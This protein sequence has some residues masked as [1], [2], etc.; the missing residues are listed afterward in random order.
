MYKSVWCRVLICLSVIV[1]LTLS[2]LPVLSHADTWDEVNP[3]YGLE[4]GQYYSNLTQE[5]FTEHAI[6]AVEKAYKLGLFGGCRPVYIF[7]DFFND[8]N[9][10]YVR[11]IT[12]TAKERG[13]MSETGTKRWLYQLSAVTGSDTEFG[14]LI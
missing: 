9:G 8:T 14:G 6:S 2:V 5:Y 10:G 11:A 1:V 4:F 7:Y 3:S 12:P 13:F